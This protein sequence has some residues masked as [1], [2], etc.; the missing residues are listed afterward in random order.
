MTTFNFDNFNKITSLTSVALSGT[1]ENRPDTGEPDS[2]VERA[3]GIT[4]YID[5]ED[6]L[7]STILAEPMEATK[8]GTSDDYQEQ[9]SIVRVLTRPTFIDAFEWSTSFPIGAKVM[10]LDLPLVILQ[11]SAI[12]ISKA[13]FNQFMTATMVVRL[14][15]SPIQFQAGR[16]YVAYEPY[17]GPRGGRASHNYPPAFT[18]LPGVIFD[19][20]KPTPMELRIP[21]SSVNTSWD[22]P[23]GNLVHGKV[24]IYVLSPLVSGTST[25]TISCNVNAWFEDAAVSVP[26]NDKMKLP[27]V[28]TKTPMHGKT[29]YLKGDFQSEKSEAQ[30][31]RFSS[32]LNTISHI[33]TALG[34]F[35]L[36]AGVAKPTASF[37]SVA[38]N[39]AAFFGFSKP[40]DTSCPTKFVSH[41]RAAWANSD[42]PLPTVKLASSVDNTVDQSGR[43]FP[44][45]LDEMEISYVVSKPAVVS[46]WLWSDTDDVGKLITVLPIH[47]GVSE[48]IPGTSALTDGLFAPTPMS[49]V[50]SMFHMWA[51]SIALRLE[52]VSTPF[53]AGRLM[54]VYIPDYNPHATY[55][56][57]EAG[58][59][60]SVVWDI[61]DSSDISF[62]V[63]YVSDSPFL[64]VVLDDQ[65]YTLTNARIPEEGER[66][67]AYRNFQNG[68]I[69]VFVLNK[70]VA[71]ST[72]SSSISVLNWYS[73]GEDL[74]F[75]SPTFGNYLPHDSGYKREDISRRW[76]DY[77]LMDTPPSTLPTLLA[78]EEKD[79]QHD[80]SILFGHH[81]SDAAA[82]GVGP[83]VI[84]PSDSLAPSRPTNERPSNKMFSAPVGSATTGASV[85]NLTS[86]QRAP[87]SQF[88]PMKRINPKS[89][90]RL[91]SGEVI[92]N[93]RVLTRRMAPAYAL[94]PHDMTDAGAAD[95]QPPTSH[96][97]L[98]ID[99][100][101]YQ[102]CSG[103]R[104]SALT[105]R[106][107]GK[108]LG[109]SNNWLTELE[110]P[111]SYISRLYGFAR[112]S[113]VYGISVR[114]SNTVNGAPF[115]TLADEVVNRA[116]LATFDMRLS[117]HMDMTITR[118]PYFRPDDGALGYND[119]TTTS[120]NENFGF[121]SYLSPNFSVEKSG[122]QGCGL[123]VT[124]PQVGKYPY[125]LLVAP[126]DTIEEY[127]K[128]YMQAA[129]RSRRMLE[130]RYRPFSSAASGVTANY[131][132]HYWPFPLTINEAAGDDHSFGMLLHPPLLTR[133]RGV[134]V[135]NNY[136]TGKQ[137][138]I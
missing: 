32:A 96:H 42:G 124:V 39:V 89:Q 31:H 25:T 93:L 30:N 65:S 44:C 49:Y 36:L 55:D 34:N 131:Q 106:M 132:P 112:G 121:N 90:A 63:P 62:E 57:E 59:F 69:V 136:T 84:P 15:A 13:Q 64:S 120:W 100:D 66:Q 98:V 109:T 16:L 3:Q 76:Y 104:D 22:L 101:Y 85:Q 5:A 138:V 105:N 135:I 48:Y 37:F 130:I 51:G 60:Y 14:Q 137:V 133:V 92:T 134:T 122:E 9:A 21:F 58:N 12:K 61:T 6:T 19:P 118:M 91:T 78:I 2:S 41:N 7:V 74:T 125:K 111:L 28:V 29:E 10:Q 24:T 20:A 4:S 87:R 83:E 35:P 94:Y 11:K 110:T 1:Q 33:A 56:I 81:E 102:S 97:V 46:Q 72:T 68:A 80:E 86:N 99:P 40:P 53:H 45:P 119:A 26:T 108:L 79:E 38:S 114:S 123:T 71:A 95:V 52:A 128:K 126:N 103:Y 47:P 88:I 17:S 67:A 116:D 50:A 117:R 115:V 43:F 18:S 127:T 129:P 107:G 27:S 113:R 82:P 75:A 23:L 70:L 77:T 54:L 8:S 73:G